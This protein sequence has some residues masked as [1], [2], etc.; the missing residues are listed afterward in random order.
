VQTCALPISALLK[1]GDVAGYQRACAGFLQAYRKG[2]DPQLNRDVL[3]KTCVL[4]PD[5]LADFGPLLRLMDQLGKVAEQRNMK[6]RYQGMR[7]ML[8]YR[9]GRSQEALECLTESVGEPSQ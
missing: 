5:A 8:L 2:R 3:V 6:Q 1:T 4:A 7:G 9:M